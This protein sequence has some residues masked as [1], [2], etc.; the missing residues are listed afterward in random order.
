[1]TKRQTGTRRGNIDGQIGQ[2]AGYP[3]YAWFGRG[4]VGTKDS[5]KIAAMFGFL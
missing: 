4:D 1:M 2:L 5:R 3:S